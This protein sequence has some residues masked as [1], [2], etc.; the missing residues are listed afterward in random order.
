MVPTYEVAP[1]QLVTARGLANTY[2]GGVD[3]PEPTAPVRTQPP[4]VEEIL[5]LC[6]RI[7]RL[8]ARL[9]ASIARDEQRD[10][11]REAAR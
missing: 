3:V 5:D 4:T 2:R 1:A 7:D 11:E 10:R 9:T 6:A 8:H